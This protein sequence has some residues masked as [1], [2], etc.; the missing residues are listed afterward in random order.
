MA[1]QNL[2]HDRRPSPTLS[3]QR[4]NATAYMRRQGFV[5]HE[6][7]F[8]ERTTDKGRPC[9]VIWN[10]LNVFCAVAEDIDDAHRWIALA[11]ARG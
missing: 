1:L 9:V 2:R 11:S 3:A 7:H 6:G 5:E 8:L 10:D 4:V